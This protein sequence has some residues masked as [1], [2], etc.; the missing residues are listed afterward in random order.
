[1]EEE[2]EKEEIN[3]MYLTDTEKTAGHSTIP[4]EAFP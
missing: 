2:K 3:C 1:M 4:L